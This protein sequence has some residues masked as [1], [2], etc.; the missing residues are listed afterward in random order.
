MNAEDAWN[1]FGR[2]CLHDIGAFRPTTVKP[3]GTQS[4]PVYTGV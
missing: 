3:S 2:W 4:D 1:G